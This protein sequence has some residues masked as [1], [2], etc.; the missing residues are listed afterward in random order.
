MAAQ[1]HDLGVSGKT[2]PIAE[3]S[4]L[5]MLVQ[6]AAKADWKSVDEKLQKK[7]QWD[8]RHFPQQPLSPAK[9]TLTTYF[10][11]GVILQHAVSAPVNTPTGYQWQVVYPKG[12]H[13][14]PLKEGLA[15]VTR[16]LFFNENI[17]AQVAFMKAALKAYPYFILPVALGGNIPKQ[18]KGIGRPMY[19]AYSTILQRFRILATPALLGVGRGKYR[20]DMAVTYFGPN[21]LKRA[22]GDPEK[23]AME[24]HDAW[25]GLTGKNQVKMLPR[26]PENVQARASLWPV[27]QPGKTLT[28][29]SADIYAGKAIARYNQEHG[30]NIQP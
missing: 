18:A 2:F 20:Y 26:A 22:D 4:F 28:G 21:A 8:V 13:V 11:P 30:T 27:H 12:T 25:F 9:S 10:S 19:Y 23:A 17:P 6:R 29:G 1:A 24:I 16:M 7:A 14:N 3:Q 15:P 5:Q